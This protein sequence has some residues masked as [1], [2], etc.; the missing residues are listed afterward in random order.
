MIIKQSFGYSQI[1]VLAD[2]ESIPG[3]WV[4]FCFISGYHDEWTLQHSYV[5]YSV[6][7]VHKSQIVINHVFKVM[8]HLL[9]YNNEAFLGLTQTPFGAQCLKDGLE[10][11]SH[12]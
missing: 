4:S 1:Q 6:I 10:R 11:K 12:F 2:C 9:L 5:S 3:K 7:Q 8:P